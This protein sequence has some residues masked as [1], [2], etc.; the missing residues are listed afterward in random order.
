MQGQIERS[1]EELREAQSRRDGWFEWIQNANRK[2][3]NQREK[4]PA[5]TKVVKSWM[6]G[7]SSYPK[8][9]QPTERSSGGVS[10]K[11]HSSDFC[12]LSQSSHELA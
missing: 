9:K 2:P 6:V 7:D 1:W 10:P 4:S 3:Q 12:N 11:L 5:D 8:E